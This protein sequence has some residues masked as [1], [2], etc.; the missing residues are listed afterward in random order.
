MPYNIIKFME[1]K[2]LS[3]GLEDYIE[4]IYI[5][6]I[7]KTQ[8]KGAQLA[9]NLNISRASVSEALA[10]LSERGLINYKSYSEITLTEKGRKEAINVYH[11][12]NVL[13]EFFEQILSV[14]SDEAED[15]SCKI[16]HFISKNALEKLRQYTLYCLRHPEIID[17]FNKES[18]L[19]S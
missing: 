14:D 8:L 3:S 11:K 19:D 1:E 7:N 4:A 12:H 18:S 6:D 15:I 17:N 13:K 16:E 2:N 10:K 5:A 9:R